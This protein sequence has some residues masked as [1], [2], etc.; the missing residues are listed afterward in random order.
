MMRIPNVPPDD[1]FDIRLEPLRAYLVDLAAGATR[2]MRHQGEG[3]EAAHHEIVTNQPI[4]GD[5]AG[6]TNTD[7]ARYQGL[8]HQHGLIAVELPRIKKAHEVLIESLAHIDNLRHRLATTFADSVEAHAAAEGGTTTLITAYEHL[9]AYRS[10]VADKAVH[11]RKKNAEARS[12]D[13]PATTT[14]AHATGETA[15]GSSQ[16]PAPPST[17][18]TS[19][20]ESPA[21]TTAVTGRPVTRSSRIPNAPPESI[22]AIDLSP[23]RDFLVD[24]P[25]GA[26]VGMRREQNGWADV[27]HEIASNQGRF[28]DRAGITVTDFNRFVALNTQYSLIHKELPRVAKAKEVLIESLANTDSMR[29]KL[30]TL[31]A[32][33]AEA[34]ASAE[35]GDPTLR[36]AY[37]KT[38]A[39]RGVTADKAAK[40]RR[41]NEEGEEGE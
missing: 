1:I 32:A 19:E 35:G 3:F 41:K 40:T 24:L 29:H 39:Y 2:G 31:F 18:A 17:D 4:I 28:G 27:C 13:S 21:S 5:R 38:I 33:A 36:T 23:F 34:H 10:V 26:T 6:I 15:E 22:F 11:S 9:I 30:M 25:A 8:H 14:P 16:P 20:S 12:S 37:E 7:F